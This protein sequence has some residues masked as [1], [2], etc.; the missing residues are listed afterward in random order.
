MPKVGN[1]HF[2]YSPRGMKSAEDYAERMGK[3]VV[4]A[5]HGTF[6][7]S[8]MQTPSEMKAVV[9]NP[10]TGITKKE[11]AFWS[12]ISRLSNTLVK[13]PNAGKKQ[14]KKGYG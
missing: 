6:V 8:E 10:K 7:S 11:E 2:A 3:K 13:G 5:A 14:N 4:Y 1:K 9:K 12:R